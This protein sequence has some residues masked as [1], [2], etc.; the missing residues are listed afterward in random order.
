M[1]ST[2]FHFEHVEAVD[3]QRGL[4]L[5]IIFLSDVSRVVFSYHN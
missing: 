4:P 1:V 3:L 2:F 5:Q